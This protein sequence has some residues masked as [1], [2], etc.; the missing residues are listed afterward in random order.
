LPDE[1]GIKSW[2]LGWVS[3]YWQA[4]FYLCVAGGVG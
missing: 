2:W 1:N 4:I 3:W